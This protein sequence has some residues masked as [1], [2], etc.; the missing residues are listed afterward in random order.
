MCLAHDGVSL[1]FGDLTTSFS[2]LSSGFPLQFLSNLELDE[3]SFS[4][5]QDLESK[6]YGKI[7]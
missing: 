4:E 3:L 6:C 5:V 1:S 7:A 2:L